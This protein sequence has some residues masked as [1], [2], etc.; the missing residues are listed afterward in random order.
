MLKII[1]KHSKK[2]KLDYL[3]LVYG[4]LVLSFNPRVLT[5]LSNLSL[6]ELRGYIESNGSFL[7][8]K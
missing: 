5:K 7:I 8:E 6:Q 1:L 4:N 2:T 3:C